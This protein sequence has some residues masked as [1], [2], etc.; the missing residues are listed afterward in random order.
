[1]CRSLCRPVGRALGVRRV[2]VS[3][4]VI[5]LAVRWYLVSV[6]SA[7]IWEPLLAIA[8]TVGGHWPDTARGACRHFVLDT[9]PSITSLGVRLLADCS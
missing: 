4:G 7:E 8:D 2:P 1:M 3:A 5:T 9:G 6:R